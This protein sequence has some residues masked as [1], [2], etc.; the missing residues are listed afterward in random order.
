[1]QFMPT[2]VPTATAAPVATETV[3]LTATAEL[4]AAPQA[5]ETPLAKATVVPTAAE[6]LRAQVAAAIAVPTVAIPTLKATAVLA[7]G[8]TCPNSKPQCIKGNIS[9]K[10]VK[11]HHLP[12][13]PPYNGT[14][15]DANKGEHMFS[16]D[17]EAI[18]EG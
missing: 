15:I 8:N 2:G 7:L 1:M 9:S 14:K 13:C 11:F 17:A 3:Q 12:E 18:A 16:S 10:R 6:T 4:I 5:T